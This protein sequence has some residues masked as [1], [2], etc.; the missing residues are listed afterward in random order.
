MNRQSTTPTGNHPPR[1][2]IV[3]NCN[4]SVFDRPEYGGF[5]GMP[6]NLRLGMVVL[7]GKTG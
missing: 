6:V 4:R 2:G 5:L 1:I 7:A 3:C